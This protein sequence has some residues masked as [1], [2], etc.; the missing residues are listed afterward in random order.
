MSVKL[1][2]PSA[3]AAN[4]SHPDH[5]RWV[6]EQTLERE[7]AHAKARGLSLRDAEKFNAHHLERLSNRR[8]RT[9]APKKKTKRDAVQRDITHEQL[10]AAGI[11]KKVPVARAQPP[12]PPCKL[13]R[14][15]VWCKRTF[16]LSQIATRARQLEPKAVSLVSEL[17]AIQFAANQRK[18]YKDAIGRELPF[19]RLKGADIDKAVNA[20]I[21][22][23]C[24]RSTSFM[25]QWR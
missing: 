17:V 24:D 10:A 9:K 6:K 5:A 8:A 21:E 16:R 20:G 14:Q 2:T 25:G 22:W 4:P 1:I 7:V 19:S 13:C 15:C 23:V 18:D 11:T 12:M 3:A